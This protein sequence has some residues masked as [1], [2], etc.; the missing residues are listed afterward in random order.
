MTTSRTP[1][2]H[3]RIGLIVGVAFTATFLGWAFFATLQG[4]VVSTGELV[5]TD[6]REIEIRHG[7]GGPVAEV[8]VESGSFVKAGDPI[9]RMDAE[10]LIV[11]QRI[12]QDRLFETRLRDHRLQT[13]IDGQ[14]FLPLPPALE[15]QNTTP[16][17]QRSVEREGAA[18]DA[19]KAQIAAG[20]AA[21][22]DAQE[23]AQRAAETA[24]MTAEG[25]EEEMILIEDD[26]TAK[27]T[28]LDKGL[29]QRATVNELERAKIQTTND[30][31]QAAAEAESQDARVGTLALERDR[32]EAEYKVSLVEELGRAAEIVPE[33]EERLAGVK[34][35]LA[36][37]EV[38]APVSGHINNLSVT[39]AGV[40]IP[41]GAVIATLVPDSGEAHI[42]TQIAPTQIDQ[43]SAG[44]KAM[45]RPM[46]RAH[47]NLELTAQ[48]VRVGEG[49]RRDPTTGVAYYEVL[50]IPNLEPLVAAGDDLVSGT[51]FEVAIETQARSPMA[52]F[53]EP[54]LRSFRRAL[55]E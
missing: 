55:R 39:T 49:V 4:A 33:L 22:D 41:P 45:L 37:L 26:L 2:R 9:L 15:A 23:Q 13:L 14:P 7:D 20:I 52:Y 29:A 27:T 31:N 21:V 48:V 8:L 43:V 24:R 3:L 44:Q 18:H 54:V 47:N 28:L 17:T 11:E 12:L 51:P 50:I 42:L 5:Y 30:R 6:T 46:T 10:L 38:R 34:E 35:R 1:A 19:S 36:R 40:V 25:L 53:M 32:I 16:E